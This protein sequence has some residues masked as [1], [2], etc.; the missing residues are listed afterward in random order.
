MSTSTL[1]T[2]MPQARINIKPYSYTGCALEKVKLPLK[3]ITMDGYSNG[4]RNRPL[5]EREKTNI[6]KIN[7]NSVQAEYPPSMNPIVENTRS[8]DYGDENIALPGERHGP[9]PAVS[10]TDAEG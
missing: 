8:G 4:K 6:N 1:Q 2:E 9:D 10:L 7:F 5:L 3:L